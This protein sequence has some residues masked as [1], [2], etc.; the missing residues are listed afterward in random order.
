MFMSINNFFPT[1]SQL[2]PGD[3]LDH[4]D[5]LSPVYAHPLTVL[6]I[7]QEPSGQQLVT[8]ATED[9]EV[10]TVDANPDAQADLTPPF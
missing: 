2:R 9:G 6:S 10:L 7:D 1:V 4:L 5:G 8:V 3:Q